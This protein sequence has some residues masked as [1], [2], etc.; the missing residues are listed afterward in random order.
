M[1]PSNWQNVPRDKPVV[2]AAIIPK[3]GA[4]SLFDYSQ[5]EPRFFAYFAAAGLGDPTIADWYR[6]GRD[7]YREI[8]GRAYKKTA[9]EITDSERQNGKV[10][11][12]M[13]LYGA[14][15]RKVAAELGLSYAEARDFYLEFHEGLPQIKA[16]SNPRPQSDRGMRYWK[17]GLVERQL[18]HRG[19][20][21]T[22]WGR[23]LHP[24]Q[25]GEHKM[26]NRLIQGSAADLLKA[27]LIR[28]DDW[29]EAN[30]DLE[31]QAVSNVH[32]EVIF[33]GPPSEVPLLHEKIP[34]LMSA[35][36]WL[37]EVVPI[38]I[39][40]EVATENWWAKTEY[41]EWKELHGEG[42]AA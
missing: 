5:I 3:R 17:P 21:K 36:P 2:K 7:V 1:I 14:G 19:Y 16:L 28:I 39:D 32:D 11:F 15:P 25:W 40:H 38:V 10:W 33:D 42:I 20:L 29:L 23:H 8:A 22:H 37:T 26:L 24:E 31:T 30:P 4:F 35:E 6:E 12:L 18:K 41:E 13:S 9:G 27:S 34:A